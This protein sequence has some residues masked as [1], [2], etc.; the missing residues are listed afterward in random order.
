MLTWQKLQAYEITLNQMKQQPLN[1]I[2]GNSNPMPIP[3]RQHGQA[4]WQL[5][6]HIWLLSSGW[7][8][9]VL[10]AAAMRAF[11]WRESRMKCESASLAFCWDASSH[12]ALKYEN[13]YW[14]FSLVVASAYCFAPCVCVWESNA[15]A[16]SSHTPQPPYITS[17]DPCQ[18]GNREGVCVVLLS[19]R[20]VC[21]MV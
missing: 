8:I 7:K 15:V 6:A 14:G 2:T 1:S 21:G 9:Q 3:P 12:L 5:P 19:K 16:S 10:T 17:E 4:T 18:H 11:L 13:C 20:F